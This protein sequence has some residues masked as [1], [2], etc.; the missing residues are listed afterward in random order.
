VSIQGLILWPVIPVCDL[1]SVYFFSMV[2]LELVISLRSQ[3]QA[4]GILLL[5]SKSI[6]FWRH[7]DEEDVSS[8]CPH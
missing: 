6:G 5:I 2:S 7:K 4:P 1:T 8:E 3:G